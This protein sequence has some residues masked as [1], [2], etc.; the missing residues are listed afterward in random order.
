ARWWLREITA[1]MLHRREEDR[2]VRCGGRF[3]CG[4]WTRRRRTITSKMTTELDAQGL[5][6]AE[7]PP[8]CG[9]CEGGEGRGAA[10]PATG[11]RAC[12]PTEWSSTI[13]AVTQP[14]RVRSVADGVQQ[15]RGHL[16]SAGAS[17]VDLV[18]WPETRS[19]RL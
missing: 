9:A 17:Q 4:C 10:E 16:N 5:R 12:S 13:R 2:Q 8:G 18:S 7:G 14:L 11:G 1:L 6:G 19:R 15:H 3:W